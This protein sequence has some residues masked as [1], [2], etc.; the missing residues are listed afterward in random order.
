MT[1]RKVTVDS[2]LR[3]RHV[4]PRVYRRLAD[5]R[6]RGLAQNA[7]SRLVHNIKAMGKALWP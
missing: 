2:L 3:R 6:T 4:R 1:R 5:R 7:V